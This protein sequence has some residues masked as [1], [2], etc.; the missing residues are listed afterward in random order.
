MEA[1]QRRKTATV[2]NHARMRA[3]IV[4]NMWPSA[5]A[6]ALGSFVRDQVDALR[7]LDGVEVEVFAFPPGGYARAARELRRRQR[8]G[9]R[10]DLVHAHFGLSA[11]PALA[12]RRTPRV[13]TLQGTEVRPPHSQHI[14]R[15]AN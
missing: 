10:F 11:W 14:T 8:R 9:E 12:V 6:P 2:E 13:V 3:L 4:T 5:S 15:A 7:E 1:L